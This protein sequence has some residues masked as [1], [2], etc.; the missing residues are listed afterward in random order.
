MEAGIIM[1]N[2]IVII[3]CRTTLVRRHV[4][5]SHIFKD[6]VLYSQAARTAEQPL[7]CHTPINTFSSALLSTV[8]LYKIPPSLEVCIR[9]AI[10]A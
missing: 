1:D 3:D 2:L 8:S 4:N 10:G 7:P 5:R 6:N 9:M